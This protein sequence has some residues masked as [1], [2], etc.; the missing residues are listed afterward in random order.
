MAYYSIANDSTISGVDGDIHKGFSGLMVGAVLRQPEEQIQWLWE[1]R[2]TEP[3]EV[4]ERNNV[5][6]GA[7]FK[8]IGS[9]FHFDEQTVS[10]LISVIIIYG[11]REN[12]L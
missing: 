3:N 1:E 9:I 2:R 5:W 12:I 7:E 4:N 10:L 11:F 8:T 6:K